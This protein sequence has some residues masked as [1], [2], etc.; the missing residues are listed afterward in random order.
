MMYNKIRKERKN[1]QKFKIQASLSF[2]FFSTS[3]GVSAC[4]IGT[5]SVS[6]VIK[7]YLVTYFVNL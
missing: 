1:D 4:E 2:V 6:L 5:I 3:T 7:S